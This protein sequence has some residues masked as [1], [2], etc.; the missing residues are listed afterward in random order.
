[1]GG[2]R[3]Q[4]QGWDVFPGD[5]VYSELYFRSLSLAR[6]GGGQR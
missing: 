5:K 6:E 2:L 4:A 3:W 1:M